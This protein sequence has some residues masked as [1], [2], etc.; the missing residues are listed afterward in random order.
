M[1]RKTAFE[2]EGIECNYEGYTMGEH[3]NGWEC[4]R[5][6]KE[7]AMQIASDY[8]ES[9]REFGQIAHYDKAADA[10]YFENPDQYDEP[11]EY[12]GHDIVCNG[13][14]FHVYAVGAWCWIWDE[15][16]PEEEED[17]E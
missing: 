10:F 12:Q 3:W 2:I 6:T 8:T 1:Y 13:E 17:E 9:G 4:P 14:K 16:I 5:F 15:V 7:I 11:E